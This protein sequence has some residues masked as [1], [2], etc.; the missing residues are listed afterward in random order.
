MGMRDVS[1]KCQ[2]ITHVC[3]S[4]VASVSSI[5]YALISL[6]QSKFWL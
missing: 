3:Y 2:N 1:T 6:L 5:H 4:E